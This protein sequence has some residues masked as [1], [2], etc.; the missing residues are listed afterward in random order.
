MRSYRYDDEVKELRLCA[1][2]GQVYVVQEM[3]FDN[4]DMIDWTMLNSNVVINLLGPRRNLKSRKDYEYINIEVPKRIA[5]ACAKNPGVLRMIHFSSAGVSPNSESLDLSTKYYG[6]Q[7]V[8]PRRIYYDM[9]GVECLPQCH[10][11]KTL[12]HR[13]QERLPGQLHS[14]TEGVL[15]SLQRRH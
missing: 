7:E 13:G 4:K 1:G 15:L 11:P 3:D 12:H 14:N 10:H 8:L 6:E 2:V 9:I 5:Q